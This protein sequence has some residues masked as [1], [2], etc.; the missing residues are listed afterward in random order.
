MEDTEIRNIKSGKQYDHLFPKSKMEVTVIKRQAKLEDTVKFLPVAIEKTLDQTEKIAQ[1]LASE[2]ETFTL[3]NMCKR[4]WD[5]S[6]DHIQ[7]RKDEPQKEQIQSPQY[8]WAVHAGDCDDF[9]VMI[10]S[11]L[12]HVEGLRIALR[13][14]MYTE[15]NGYQHIYP[16]VFLPD[17]RQITMDC[18]AKKFNYEVPYLKKIDKNMELQFLNGLPDTR[19]NTAKQS[20]DAD[21]LLDGYDGDDVGDLGRG[22]TKAK[23]KGKFREKLK[24][25]VKKVQ[26]SKVAT[27]VRKGLHVANR[28]NP[29]A[30]LLRTG[31]LTAL[32]TNLFKIAE[33]LRYSY[34]T[35][36]QATAM[37][38]DMAKYN[39]LIGIRDQLEK[40]F[41]RAGGKIENFKKNILTG[42]GNRDKQVPLSGLGAIDFND[43]TQQNTLQQILGVQMYNSEVQGVEGFGEL[44]VAT[45]AAVAAA[46]TVLSAIAALL[47]SIGDIRKKKGGSGGESER[48]SDNT[49]ESSSDSSSDTPSTDSSNDVNTESGASFSDESSSVD[50]TQNGTDLNKN[51]KSNGGGSGNSGSSTGT[52]TSSDKAEDSTSQETETNDNSTG[53]SSENADEG[54]GAKSAAR[55]TSTTKATEVGF[56]TK[57]KNWAKA[58]PLPATGIALVVAGGITYGLVKAFSGDKKDHKAK[59]ALAGLPHKKK[60]R[61]KKHFHS[62]KI[63]V[64]KLR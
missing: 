29:A 1:Q 56:L 5:W 45:T 2:L 51:L 8:T 40:V 31:I 50:Q 28:L 53:D 49:S 12:S 63:K 14:S 42:R 16:V 35:P 6:Y 34:L 43:Y 38:L 59:G 55:G 21:D 39:R 60:N 54:T 19:T 37:N 44:G 58:N 25:V 27:V 57:I 48:N 11:I 24:T 61:K 20:I 10:V 22:K 18:V 7:Y 17:G 32:K 15:E 52:P 13:I 41:F 30:A 33:R 62:H 47:K 4:V 23:A 36:Q 64:Q 26:N 9:T 3:F 46:T